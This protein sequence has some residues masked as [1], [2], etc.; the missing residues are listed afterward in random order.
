MSTMVRMKTMF[1]FIPPRIEDIQQLNQ[2]TNI[3]QIIA[4]SHDLTPKGGLVGEIPENFRDIQVGEIL[5]H[6][7]R[8]IYIYTWIFPSVQNLCV[9]TQKTYQKAEIYISRRSRYIYIYTHKIHTVIDSLPNQ[10]FAACSS[11]I[12]WH[13]A[14]SLARVTLFLNGVLR[15]F[16]VPIRGWFATS[17]TRMYNI[18]IGLLFKNM[19]ALGLNWFMHPNPSSIHVYKHL[20]CVPVVSKTFL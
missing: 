8:Y 15:S 1:F 19:I 16:R 12:L 4:T 11:Q 18:F 14:K 20:K 13:I 2:E 10:R 5:F 17:F 9:F 6:L 3:Y 7:A